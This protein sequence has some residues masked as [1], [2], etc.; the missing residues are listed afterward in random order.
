MIF[1]CHL[2]N[3]TIY[4]PHD[5]LC[6]NCL[7]FLKEPAPR[8]CR[9]CG[10][11]QCLSSVCSRP[12]TLHPRIYSY[13]A[14]YLSVGGTHKI[15]RN[16]KKRGGI[17]LDR[18][19]FSPLQERIQQAQKSIGNPAGIIPIPQR[20]RRSFTLGRNPVEVFSRRMSKILQIP[21]LFALRVGDLRGQKQSLMKLY[22]RL[23]HSRR[24]IP[25]VQAIQ[26]ERKRPLLD[27]LITDD[28]FTSGHTL[29]S[30]VQVLD[31]FL[32]QDCRLHVFCLGFRPALQIPPEDRG[33]LLNC[34]TRS[35]PIG[36]ELN[37]L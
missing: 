29:R 15:L 17:F 20:L 23:S 33:N 13:H 4:S 10:G 32:P 26:K 9:S 19:I 14:V 34:E 18:K 1:L 16:W 36:E 22:G 28:F 35:I 2:C 5:S 11:L 7:L 6:S 24:F 3:E 31:P 8:L 37:P 21:L 30:A 12:W 25:Q 27:V